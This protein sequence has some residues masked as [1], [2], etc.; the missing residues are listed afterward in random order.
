MPRADDISPV[1]F[2]FASIPAQTNPLGVKG[3]SEA[4]NIAAPPAIVNAI[5]DA[6]ASLGVHDLAL[7]V[8]PEHVW[9][10]MNRFGSD[11][12]KI[13]AADSCKDMT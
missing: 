11:S 6:L 4:G 9:R 5:I 12:A 3:G 1:D 2:R 8:R 10:A 13:A 7:P